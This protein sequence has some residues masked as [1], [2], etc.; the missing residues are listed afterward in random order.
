M[1]IRIRVLM[2]SLSPILFISPLC[3][4]ADSTQTREAVRQLYSVEVTSIGDAHLGKPMLVSIKVTNI[5]GSALA[6]RSRSFYP[7]YSYYKW[8]LVQ[9]GKPVE[10]TAFHRMLFGEQLPS[11]PP[12]IA[13]GSSMYSQIQPK[14]GFEMDADVS[15]MYAIRTTGKYLL[16]VVLRDQGGADVKSNIL[17]LNVE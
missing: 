15:K 5:S 2:L 6:F 4:V 12:A 8:S 3:V 1:D 10:T 17:T 14:E 13:S 16:Q 9:D 7:A 11:D